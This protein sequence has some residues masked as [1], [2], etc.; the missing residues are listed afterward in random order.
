VRRKDELIDQLQRSV[1]GPAW[2]GDALAQLLA[3]VTAE[4]ARF[5][6]APDVHSI[7]EITLHIAAWAREVA[8]RMR[9]NQPGEPAGGDWRKAQGRDDKAWE[10]AIQEVFDA[11][12]ELIA[13]IRKQ[14]EAD[15]ET[16]IGTN[17]EPALATG[18]SRA[19][20]VLGVIQ[21]NAYHGGQIALL[22]KR[23][24]PA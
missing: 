14:S 11:C 9:G 10:A 16:M 20:S 3:D 12:D 24:T 7:W 1:S 4:E 23:I 22:K 18:F 15:L 13:E 21:H 6:P 17:P 19:A 5:R 2:H 8:S